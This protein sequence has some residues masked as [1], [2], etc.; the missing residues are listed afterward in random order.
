MARTEWKLRFAP[1]LGIW[2]P[3]APLFKHCAGIDP[4]SQI[5]YLAELGFAGVQDNCL[6]SRTP[7]VQNKMGEELARHGL[8]MGCFTFSSRESWDKPMWGTDEDMPRSITSSA[9]CARS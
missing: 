2:S 9:T 7:E 4:M 1:H 8:K 3:D 6:K 5:Q